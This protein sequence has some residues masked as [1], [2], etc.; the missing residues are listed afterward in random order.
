MLNFIEAKSGED[1]KEVRLRN[2]V[3][4]VTMVN[5][6]TGKSNPI[7]HIRILVIGL[8]LAWNGGSCRWMSLAFDK[9]HEISVYWG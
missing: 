9:T 8:E 3:A 6:I 1:V 4:L 7:A 2:G 5:D